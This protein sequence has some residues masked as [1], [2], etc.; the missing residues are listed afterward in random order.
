MTYIWKIAPFDKRPQSFWAVFDLG[1]R[2]Y[3][4]CCFDVPE[5]ERTAR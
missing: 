5:W 3:L 4:R 1:E 2:K